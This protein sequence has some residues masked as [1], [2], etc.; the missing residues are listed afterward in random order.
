MDFYTFM[1]GI[2]GFYIVCIG[3]FFAAI[4][5]YPVYKKWKKKRVPRFHKVMVDTDGTITFR[6]RTRVLISLKQDDGPENK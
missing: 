6:S 5:L 3:G 1:F 2:L 4:Y